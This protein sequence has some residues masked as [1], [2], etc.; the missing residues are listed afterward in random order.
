M[1]APLYQ[2][3]QSRNGSCLR[4]AGVA[5]V[6]FRN[7][8]TNEDGESSRENNGESLNPANKNVCSE[9]RFG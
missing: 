5:V 8:D 6:C 3:L 4:G 9:A 2:F 1:P 7:A